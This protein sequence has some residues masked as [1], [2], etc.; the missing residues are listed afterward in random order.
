MAH[1]AE[2]R[3]LHDFRSVAPLRALDEILAEALVPQHEAH[4]GMPARQIHAVR[5]DMHGIG[6]A[7]PLVMRIGIANELRRQRIEKRL[8]RRGCLGVLAHGASCGLPD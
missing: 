5:R 4:L 3:L 7:Q 6:A 1:A 2:D 8:R